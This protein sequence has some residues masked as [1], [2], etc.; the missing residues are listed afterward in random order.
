[1]KLGIPNREE[2]ILIVKV[3]AM[4]GIIALLAKCGY[5]DAIIGWLAL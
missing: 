4:T 3:L 2:T 5:Y 1:M